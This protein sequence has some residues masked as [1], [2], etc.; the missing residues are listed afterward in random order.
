MQINTVIYRCMR[1]RTCGDE[2]M[3]VLL[4]GV[5]QELGKECECGPSKLSWQMK[6]V[7]DGFMA[8]WKERP[9]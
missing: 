2:W 6:T 7:P 1:C 3:R 8:V 5:K 9:Q 4:P